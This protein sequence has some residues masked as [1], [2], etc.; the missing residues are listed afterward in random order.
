MTAATRSLKQPSI[1]GAA[2]FAEVQRDLAAT[3]KI[4]LWHEPE[5]HYWAILRDD[6]PV[7]IVSAEGRVDRQGRQL[8]LAT[9]NEANARRMLPLVIAA[10]GDLLP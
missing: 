2:G 1:R 6:T 5:S 9:E 7:A 4:G 8:N 10:L 3:P